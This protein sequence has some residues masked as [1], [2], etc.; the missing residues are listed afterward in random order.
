MG[1]STIRKDSYKP[2]FFVTK[3]CNQVV[4]LLSSYYLSY[5]LLFK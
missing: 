4:T 1:N 5:Y 3:V 2:L